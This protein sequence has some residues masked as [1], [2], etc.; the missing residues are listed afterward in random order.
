MIT[1][2]GSTGISL[3]AERRDATRRQFLD[4]GQLNFGK[5]KKDKVVAVASAPIADGAPSFGSTKK[6][7]K[8]DYRF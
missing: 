6:K 4:V 3:H 8:L 7:S 5:R 1:E 2:A